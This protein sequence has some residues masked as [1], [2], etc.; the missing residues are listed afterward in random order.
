M[1]D[2]ANRKKTPKQ[3]TKGHTAQRSE[4]TK[5]HFKHAQE[6]DIHFFHLAIY[7]EQRNHSHTLIRTTQQYIWAWEMLSIRMKSFVL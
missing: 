6:K 4:K 2:A 7:R 1:F 5:K 3:N